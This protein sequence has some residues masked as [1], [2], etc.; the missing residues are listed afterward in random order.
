MGTGQHGSSVNHFS[1]L[2]LSFPC[3]VFRAVGRTCLNLRHDLQNS[4]EKLAEWQQK[5]LISWL[6]NKDQLAQ[7]GPEEQ[8]YLTSR[9]FSL[10]K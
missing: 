8:K 7:P 1:L 10:C 6:T 9:F 2:F 3:S 5:R 4:K